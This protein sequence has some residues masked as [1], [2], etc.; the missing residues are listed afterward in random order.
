MILAFIQLKPFLMRF[1]VK[2]LLFFLLNSFRLVLAASS[3]RDMSQFASIVE[4]IYNY[5]FLFN[6]ACIRNIQT[7]GV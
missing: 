5:Y 2:N 7:Q 6:C 1:P 3:N 4:Y